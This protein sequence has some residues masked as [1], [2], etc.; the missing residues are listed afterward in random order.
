MGFDCLFYSTSLAL[1]LYVVCS[2]LS[3][4]TVSTYLYMFIY[5]F[6]FGCWLTLSNRIRFARATNT[7]QRTNNN[8]IRPPQNFLKRES[9][10]VSFLAVRRKTEGTLR[11]RKTSR[12]MEIVYA[13]TYTEGIISK[14][15]NNKENRWLLELRTR[16]DS[17]RAEYSVYAVLCVTA[18]TQR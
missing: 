1:F 8:S 11:P 4:A 7:A 14:K 12:K 10:S 6:V 15:N 18:V 13:H 3:S 17:A 2:L 5:S 16:T 9:K